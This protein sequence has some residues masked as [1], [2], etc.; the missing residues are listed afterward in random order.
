MAEAKKTTTKPSVAGAKQSAEK[1]SKAAQEV[2]GKLKTHF[3]PK[4]VDAWQKKWL[5][6]PA[7][8]KKY[9]KLSDAPNVAGAELKAMANDIIDFAQGQEG[10]KSDVFKK[11]K[12]KMSGFLKNPIAFLQAKVAK[13]KEMAKKS[14]AQA[15]SG[16]VKTKKAAKK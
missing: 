7:N 16:A 11:V 8:R 13:G 1:V 12:S 2:F 5:E 9:E 14:A 15:K 10:G 3:E 4:K 6:V